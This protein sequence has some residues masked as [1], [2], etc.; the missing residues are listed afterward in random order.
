[1]NLYPR[2]DCLASSVIFRRPSIIGSLGFSSC[3][4]ML[5]KLFLMTFGG[6]S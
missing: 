4:A 1:M 3:R 6:T 5:G 2:I